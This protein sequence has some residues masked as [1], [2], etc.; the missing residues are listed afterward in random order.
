MRWRVSVAHL[1]LQEEVVSMADDVLH[2]KRSM[3]LLVR[4]E[5]RQF[6]THHQ[7]FHHQLAVFWVLEGIEHR[8]NS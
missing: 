2:H 4:V 1:V 3:E 6:S 5:V 8:L 7:H